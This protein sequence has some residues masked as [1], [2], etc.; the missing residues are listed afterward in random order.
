MKDLRLKVDEITE[1]IEFVKDSVNRIHILQNHLS[2]SFFDKFRN[3]EASDI[4]SVVLLLYNMKVCTPF[5]YMI[6]DYACKAI[7][8]LDKLIKEVNKLSEKE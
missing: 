3:V 8:D 4:E 2:D 5:F 6:D 1:T 7:D